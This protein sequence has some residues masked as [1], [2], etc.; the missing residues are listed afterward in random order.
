MMSIT[1]TTKLRRKANECQEIEIVTL[2]KVVRER[3]TDKVAFEQRSE[4][5]EEAGKE[6][7]RLIEQQVQRPCDDC[8]QGGS[9]D[10]YY[11]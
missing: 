4:G 9:K 3:L 11:V 2:H 5:S 6:G 1:E 10:Y 8:I 7:C